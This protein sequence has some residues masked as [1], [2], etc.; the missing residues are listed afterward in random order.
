[1][2]SEWLLPSDGQTGG[3]QD[4]LET[5]VMLQSQYIIV[6]FIELYLYVVYV[7]V[8]SKL[9]LYFGSVPLNLYGMLGHSN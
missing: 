2:D 8:S 5:S 1:M 7:Q 3:F 9:K 4:L 6:K